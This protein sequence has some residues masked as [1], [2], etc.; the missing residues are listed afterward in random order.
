MQGLLLINKPEGITSFKAVAI[1]RR[2]TDTK[3][4][5]HTG[6][7]DPLATGVLPILIGRATGLSDYLLNS[8]KRYTATVK[9][10]ISTDTLDITGEVLSENEPDFTQEKLKEALEKLT[11]KQLQYPP[12]FSAIKKDGVPL[13][14]LARKGQEVVVQPREITVHSIKL[15]EF[16]PKEYTFKIDVLCSKGTYIRS[17]CRDI[18]EYL[19]CGAV[20]TE[21]TRTKTGSFSL[22]QCVDLDSL[23]TENI[24]EYLLDE[25]L[26]VEHLPCINVSEKQ[27]VRFSNGG[28]LD[29][30]RLKGEIS[31]G[32]YYRIKHNE[33]FIGIGYADGEKREIR[34]KCLI[35]PI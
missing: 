8:D 19:G 27:A 9:A 6:T 15:L 26:A 23:N 31:D 25:E 17:L 16:S 1:L 33:S 28:K 5:G 11:G 22:E 13:Y 7:L 14:K 35:N 20:M 4:I 3:K 24:S 12:V 30:D 34:I 21:L 32:N 10:G 29:F 2:I 18:G